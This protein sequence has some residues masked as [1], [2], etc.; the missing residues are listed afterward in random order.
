MMMTDNDDGRVL[1]CYPFETLDDANWV[2]AEI[3]PTMAAIGGQMRVVE[4]ELWI[5]L[6]MDVRP[7]TIKTLLYFSFPYAVIGTGRFPV[8]ERSSG[9]STKAA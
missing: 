9:R 4:T 8:R 6:P 7:E 2:S 1:Y 5:S 3:A